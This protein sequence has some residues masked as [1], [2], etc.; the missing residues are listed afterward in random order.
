MESNTNTMTVKNMTVA[1]SQQIICEMTIAQLMSDEPLVIISSYPEEADREILINTFLTVAQDNKI[2]TSEKYLKKMVEVMRE[3]LNDDNA[4]E[5]KNGSLIVSSTS[6]AT[7]V[8]DETTDITERIVKE[9]TLEEAAETIN[10]MEGPTLSSKKPIEIICQFPKEIDREMLIGLL[11]EKA[12]KCK[13]NMTKSMIKQRVKAQDKDLAIA[14]KE[15][16]SEEIKKHSH[17]VCPAAL[18]ITD[19][20]IKKMITGPYS[21]SIEDGVVYDPVT[22]APYQICPQAVLPLGRLYNPDTG[23]YMIKIA[24]LNN[25]DWTTVIVAREI[26]ANSK[27]LIEALAAKG[28]AI[29]EVNAKTIST[30]LIEIEQWNIKQLPQGEAVSVLGWADNEFT[31]FVPYIN[32]LTFVGNEMQKNLFNSIHENGDYEAWKIS[33]R[34]IR[35]RST[36]AR[37]ALAASFASILLQ[38]A[39]HNPIIYHIW[40]RASGGK[41]TLLYLCAS[42]WADPRRYLLTFNATDNSLETNTAFL[43]NL[44][45]CIDELQTAV[46]N[47]IKNPQ[48]L[49][50][51]L[52]E[53]ISRG[54]TTR[55]GEQ[56]QLK[57]FHNSIICNGEEPLTGDDANDGALNRVMNIHITDS[58][59]DSTTLTNLC[60]TV[61][62][63]YGFAGKQFLELF[64]A[65]K[66]IIPI[67]LKGYR[68]CLISKGVEPRQA[69][70]GAFTLLADHMSQEIFGDE[71]YLGIDDILP[72]LRKKNETPAA[73]NYL[74][75]LYSTFAA[76]RKHF[77]VD[78]DTTPFI[79][80]WGYTDDKYYYLHS[81]VF[82]DFAKDMGFKKNVILAYMR[83]HKLTTLAEGQSRLSTTHTRR[84]TGSGIPGDKEVQKVSVVPFIK[85]PPFLSD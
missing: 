23:N 71:L 33:V 62:A 57:Y 6:T 21:V 38:K 3:D 7:G 70:I 75:D 22:G 56:R 55:N 29:N 69:R 48:G 19:V 45:A 10:K 25:G 54:R 36:V 83:D 18:A 12:K 9:L 74:I 32:D 2:V 81:H 59:A 37:I 4:E 67:R 77:D 20:P 68:D 1:K 73:E 8:T 16:M 13:L 79:D 65:Q 80:E 66:D 60:E 5:E 27:K 34:A 41:S 28:L 52:G 78:P 40:G 43:K 84:R 61:F 47:G 82:T 11:F 64:Q 30:Y 44:P 51:K 85:N 46:A 58:I 15:H 76:N 35:A 24:F 14:A 50:Y 53:G 42:V 17:S 49:V 31:K 72:Y 26:I 39:N 63:N